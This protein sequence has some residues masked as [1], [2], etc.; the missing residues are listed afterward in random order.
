M[1]YYK[2]IDECKFGFANELFTENEMQKRFNCNGQTFETI[3]VNIPLFAKSFKIVNISQ[4]RTYK[5]ALRHRFTIGES[6]EQDEKGCFRY[7]WCGKRSYYYLFDDI[8][9]A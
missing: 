4:K 1:K 9:S 8:G 3:M 2:C 6:W 5:D 7:D